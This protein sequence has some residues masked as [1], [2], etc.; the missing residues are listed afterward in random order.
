LDRKETREGTFYLLLFSPS[1]SKGEGWDG[2]DVAAGTAAVASPLTT[3]FIRICDI[4]SPRPSHPSRGYCKEPVKGERE[5]LVT[6]P[7]EF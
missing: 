4:P 3:H 6:C 2:G 1:P 5:E 7:P